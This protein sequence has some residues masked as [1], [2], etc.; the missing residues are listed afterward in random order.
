[1]RKLRFALTAVLVVVSTSATLVATSAPAPAGELVLPPTTTA[2]ERIVDDYNARN[3]LNNA[4]LNVEGQAE[5]E[6]PPIKTIDD[7]VFREYRGRGETTL[8]DPFTVNEVE[9]FVPDQS[10][11]P[12]TFFALERLTSPE[13]PDEPT[14]QLL[15]FAQASADEPWKA[16]LAASFLPE[17]DVPDVA[18][19]D[20]GLATLVKGKQAASLQVNPRKLAP[21]L[22]RLWQRSA[23]GGAI[24]KPFEP[25]LLTTDAVALFLGEIEQL[26]INEARVDF[27]FRPSE[28][29][30]VCV[31]ARD[32]GALCFFVI[33]YSATLDPVSGAF[34][35]PLT[36]ETLTGLVVPGEY[37]S[38]TFERAAI[39]LAAVPKR[40]RLGRVDVVGVYNGLISVETSPRGVGAPDDAV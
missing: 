3:T 8:G 10:S 34:E 1:M 40:T 29:Q 6:A 18:T 13:L 19:D 39:V 23:A 27:A 17:A 15:A 28:S 25:G 5:I 36:R 26:P 14:T 11:Y 38:V 12:L 30:P 20:H 31:A 35:Q 37:G 16:T 4:T 33:S 32:G 7:S 21:K 22:A 2:A 24:S 9:V